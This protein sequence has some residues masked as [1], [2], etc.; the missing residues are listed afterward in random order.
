[1]TAFADV[2]ERKEVKYRLDARQAETMHR[3]LEGRME[4]DAYGR[5]TVRSLYLDTP[6]R[7]LI[8]RS[9]DKPLYKEKLRLRCYG[10]LHDDGLVFVEI[11]KKFEGIVYKRRVGCSYAAARAYLGG[12]PYQDACARFPW[13]IRLRRPSRA[14]RAASRLP[15]RST[16]SSRVTHPLRPLCS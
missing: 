9:L 10:A 16:S 3:A 2:F 1:M 12:M 7:T 4:P 15:P 5:T 6:E 13:P 14:R 8:E 11:K